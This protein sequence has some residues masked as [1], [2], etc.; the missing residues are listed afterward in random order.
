MFIRI[1]AVQ[2]QLAAFA[3]ALFFAAVMIVAA[4]PVVPIA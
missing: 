2:S 4:A 3:G 1:E